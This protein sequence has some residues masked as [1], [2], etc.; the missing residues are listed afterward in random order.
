M[1]IQPLFWG[2]FGR[3]HCIRLSNRPKENLTSRYKL[4]LSE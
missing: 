1:A 2:A 3:W 4:N